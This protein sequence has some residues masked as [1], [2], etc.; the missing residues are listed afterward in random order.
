[1]VVE[2][3]RWLGMLALAWGLAGCSLQPFEAAG[4]AEPTQ[5]TE[6]AQ[7]AYS[8]GD[9]VEAARLYERAAEQN[10][11]QVANYL[12]LGKSYLAQSQFTR[13]ESALN[14]ARQL[15]PRNPEVHTTLGA[16]A[17]NRL[18]PAQALEHYQAAL[19]SDGRN[20]SGYI[21]KAL[22]YDYLSRHAEA[23][24]VYAEAL[25]HYPTNF[26]LLNNRALSLVLSGRIGEG[27]TLLEELLRDPDRGNTARTNMAIAYALDGRE[28]DA[29][30]ILAGVMSPQEA[31]AALTQYRRLRTEY[32]A[33]KPIGY[34]VFQ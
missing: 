11:K 20:L 6:V 31:S 18:Q 22:S 3:R 19:N 24:T 27:T 10:P 17:L 34:L 28:R 12:G 25:R 1:M 32:L 15:A 5:T 9:F 14:H 26:A 30:A 8:V 29:R 2:Q 4:S 13:A 7:A 16:L 33:G 23:Q 21:G